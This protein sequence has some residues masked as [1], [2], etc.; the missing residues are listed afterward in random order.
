MIC[1]KYY[2][3]FTGKGFVVAASVLEGDYLDNYQRIDPIRSVSLNRKE[4]FFVIY[5][6]I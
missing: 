2:C 5:I 6:Y 3:Y 4:L 1:S